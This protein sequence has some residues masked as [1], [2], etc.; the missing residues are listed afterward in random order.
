MPSTVD[1]NERLAVESQWFVDAV[2]IDRSNVAPANFLGFDTV[3][4]EGITHL[5]GAPAD[6]NISLSS[7]GQALKIQA[8]RSKY[9]VQPTEVEIRRDPQNAPYLHIGLVYLEADAPPGFAAAMLWRIARGCHTLGISRITLEAVG[10]RTT[11]AAGDGQRITGYYAWPR[12]GFEGLVQDPADTA[13]FRQF[14]HFPA[15]VSDGSVTSL[16][17]LFSRRGGRQFWLIAGT[18]RALAFEVAPTSRSVIT[19][20]KYL[21]EKGFL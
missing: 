16:L 4:D 9:F 2:P 6:A 21:N 7:N 19:L 11:G 12:Y 1:L 15:G 10:G 3:Q 20:Y 5:C 8:S 17:D 18:R 14:R 13:L